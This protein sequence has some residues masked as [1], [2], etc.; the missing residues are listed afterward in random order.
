M[1]SRVVVSA[2][3]KVA[4]QERDIL[5]NQLPN[6]GRFFERPVIFAHC[7]IGTENNFDSSILLEVGT[8]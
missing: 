7:N 4:F 3:E 2:F 8:D 6:S 1:G 5:I